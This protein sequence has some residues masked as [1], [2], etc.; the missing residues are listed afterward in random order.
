MPKLIDH[1]Q[2]STEWWAARNGKPS[3][4]NAKKLITSTGAKSKSMEGYS[5]FLAG[6]LYANKDID[7]FE[8]NKFTDRGTDTEDE[9]RKYY[10][11]MMN[12]EVEE[13]GSFTDDLGQYIASPDGVVGS[14]LLEIKV[15]KPEN[16]INAIIYYSKNKKPPPLYVPQCQMSLFVSE[17][18]FIDLEFYNPDLP[19]L[20]IR[21]HPDKKIHDSL[22]EQLKSCVAQRNITLK[23]LKE[24]A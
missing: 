2:Y 13:I 5:S 7:P 16:H 11:F 23:L 22:N 10:Q 9:A 24:L 21:I 19:Q 8:G 3:A 17:K 6:C 15:L 1:P 20:I 4:S 12:V 14:G 18:E